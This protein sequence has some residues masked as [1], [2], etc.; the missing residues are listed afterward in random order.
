M[1]F[2]IKLFIIFFYLGFLL[3][4]GFGKR[5]G[6]A[7]WHMFSSLLTTEFNLWIVHK[8]GTKEFL[9]TWKYL[10]HTHVAMDK[11][12]TRLFLIYLKKV[13]SLNLIG[14]VCIKQ[15]HQQIIYNIEN[16]NVVD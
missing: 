2:K 9:N 10:P 8:N 14:F 1:E 11:Q 7:S 5:I 3:Y 13:H 4:K 12:E 15:G 16:S 6:F